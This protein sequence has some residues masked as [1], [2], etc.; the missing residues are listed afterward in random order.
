M[1][2]TIKKGAGLRNIQRALK[3]IEQPKKGLKSS[4]HCGVLKIRKDA[5]K[6]QKNLRNEW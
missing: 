6:I 3:N 4:K 5:L 1:V 2:T